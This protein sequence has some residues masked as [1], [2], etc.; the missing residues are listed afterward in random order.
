MYSKTANNHNDIRTSESGI[1]SSKESSVPWKMC[2]ADI[3]EEKAQRNRPSSLALRMIFKILI[4]A[5]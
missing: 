4:S 3:I 5:D 2:S 1:K